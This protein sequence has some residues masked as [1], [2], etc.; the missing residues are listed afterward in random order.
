MSKFW[1]LIIIVVIAFASLF[2]FR[3]GKPEAKVLGTETSREDPNHPIEI[4]YGSTQIDTLNKMLE[5]LN[6]VVYPEDK[7]NALPDPILR[8]GSKI[9]IMRATP[10]ELTD[11]KV[12]KVYRTWAK[13]VGE[14]IQE[15]KLD[16]LGQDSVEPTEETEIYYNMSI[17]ITRVAEVEVTEKE[18][19]DF[20]TQK[21]EDRDL[22]RGQTRVEQKGEKGVKEVKY[23]IKR[24]DGEEVSRKVLDTNITKD[25]VTEILIIGIG[26]K[27]VHSGPFVDLLNEAA[28]KYLINAT[29]L[30]CL[31]LRESG[32]TPEAEYGCEEGDNFCFK[33]LFQYEE[34]YWNDASAR[35]GYGGWSI[36]NAEAQ[37]F[38]TAHELA[39]G[40]G[41][42]WPPYINYCQGK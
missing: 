32:G 29:A 3:S 17:K 9:T 39:R 26:P 14:F 23:L 30:Q 11:A 31:M 16:L 38:T 7:L 8:I 24:V 40:Q 20:K 33:G 25:P 1:G 12:K 2:I 5:D 4:Y 35:S 37:I 34:G 10:L 15:N 42:R 19:I 6:V 41:R 13:T 18:E 28:K 27:L 21:K 36:F 22:E